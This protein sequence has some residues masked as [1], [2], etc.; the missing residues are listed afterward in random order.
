MTNKQ[1]EE[2]IKEFDDAVDLIL[3]GFVIGKNRTKRYLM[4]KTKKEIVDLFSQA[5]K[6]AEERGRKEETQ[7]QRVIRKSENGEIAWGDVTIRVSICGLSMTRFCSVKDFNET[8]D[9]MKTLPVA[10][11]KKTLKTK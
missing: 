3:I 4:G 10:K 8:L 2:V 6:E 9:D 7:L 11:M 5:I 1:T